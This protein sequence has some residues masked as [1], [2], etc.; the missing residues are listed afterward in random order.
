MAWDNEPHEEAS[1]IALDGTSW[2]GLEQTW[3]AT[4]GFK[5]ESSAAD[6]TNSMHD[7]SSDHSSP[8]A[9]A[10]L[11][12]NNYGPNSLT[13]KVLD[14]LGEDTLGEVSDEPTYR[15]SVIAGLNPSTAMDQLPLA[16]QD[17]A[18][19]ASRQEHTFESDAAEHES[20]SA[21]EDLETH[22][23]A[24]TPASDGPDGE[25][26]F[27]DYASRY[28]LRPQSS[29][30]GFMS[31]WMDKDDTGDYDP[32][33]EFRRP[34]TRRTR[35]KLRERDYV[36]S[37]FDSA[38]E[39]AAS[40]D[41]E[42]DE[43][44]KLIIQLKFSSEAGK[45][46][47]R[48]HVSS[49]PTRPGGER[50]AFSTGYRLRK[51]TLAAASHGSSTQH[52]D[53]LA[54]APDVPDDLTGHPIARGCW[55]CLGLGIRCP[56]L[57]DEGAWPCATCF[58]DKHDC[59]LVTPPDRK[60]TCERCKRRRTA[61]SYTETFDHSG[62][63]EDCAND[64]FRC[65]A[66]P[67]KDSIRTCARY[68]R[69]W[70]NDPQTSKKTDRLK[71]TY[72]TCMQC[73]EAGSPCSFSNGAVSE[74]CTSCDQLGSICI[75]EKVTTPQHHRATPRSVLAPKKRAEQ[76]PAE[77]QTPTKQAKTSLHQAPKKRAAQEP[78]EQH[79]PTKQAKSS[80]HQAP[81][82]RAAQGPAEQQIPTKQVKTSP[83]SAGSTKTII[84]KF[85]HPMNFNHEDP[86]GT[87][88]C[89]F[90]EYDSFAILGL[91]AKEVEV[92]DWA[93]GR[94]LT[95]VD[96]GHME[97]GVA[98]TKMCTTCTMR[99]VP[100]IMCPRHV[101][102]PMPGISLEN[103][104][105]DGALMA[106]FSGEAGKGERWCDVCP[107]LATYEC[108]AEG[109]TDA[110]GEPCA[111]CGLSLCEP[112][113]LSLTGVYD[114]DWQTM[115]AELKDELSAEKPLGLRADFE[116]LKQDGLLMRHVLWSAPL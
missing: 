36:G 37:I 14:G 92:I 101:M 90:C 63:C 51:K 50:D 83:H 115:L 11:K 55:E 103:I 72:W 7:I 2:T 69:D 76:Q 8:P 44:L 47:F 59:D 20:T 111:G 94:G 62:P 64:G 46:S 12:D 56:L 98:S 97:G 70:A 18:T 93:D 89:S 116:L 53:R 4:E 108:E 35:L 100:T 112:C 21:M 32:S 99:R 45:A 17:T 68:D 91:E 95:E 29:R 106:L 75:P 19:P 54:D 10:G 86:D 73:R 42:P 84:T 57:D 85:C 96:G 110:A 31:T 104:D 16:P 26:L 102:R 33:E 67:L 40:G 113:M 24:A 3:P 105:I 82:K 13:P 25:D 88:P 28:E 34:K 87:Q 58:E 107:S 6:D 71:K 79:T 22:L 61:C 9:T 27:E 23:V 30:A 5:T 49:V 66:G 80:P 38:D 15:E 65:V 114:G 109:S 43:H 48:R 41:T 1:R 74:D 52:L 81:K 77:Q 78:A 60:L 39:D